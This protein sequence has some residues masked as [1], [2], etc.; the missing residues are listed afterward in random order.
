MQFGRDPLAAVALMLVPE[1]FRRCGLRD[2]GPD[3]QLAPDSGQPPVVQLGSK[4]A[5]REA[6]AAEPLSLEEVCLGG[7]KTEKAD[8]R[9]AGAGVGRHEG[10]RCKAILLSQRDHSLTLGVQ[11]RQ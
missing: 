4:Q 2:S 6:E 10:S 11:H 3:D 5:G 9:V 7:S 8:P 1:R